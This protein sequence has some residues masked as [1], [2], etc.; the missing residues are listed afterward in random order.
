VFE[1]ALPGAGVGS[2][3]GGGRYDGLVSRFLEENIP[4]T[5]ASIGLD[6]LIMGL[7]NLKLDLVSGEGPAPV[8]VLTLNGVPQS[9][10]SR[11]AAELRQA[12]VGAEVYLG[13][14]IGRMG[15]QLSYANTRKFSLAIIVGESEL[16]SGMVS[17]KDLRAGSA[18]RADAK[19][20][21]E[22]LA[23]GTAGQHTVPRTELISVVQTLLAQ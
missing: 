18:A 20:R 19:E 16:E 14:H 7:R 17:I 3:I 1:G 10:M 8:L 11:V 13:E 15:R 22:Y 2:V 23:S 4:A 12:G 6:R 5:G 9:E 21:E